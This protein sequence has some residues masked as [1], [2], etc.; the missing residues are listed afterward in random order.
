MKKTAIQTTLA[1]I[2]AACIATPVLGQNIEAGIDL[3]YLGLAQSEGQAVGFGFTAAPEI[4]VR[5]TTPSG[6]TFGLDAFRLQGTS[7]DP[8]TDYVAIMM[9]SID[10]T[11]GKNIDLGS[12]TQAMLYGGLRYATY[13]EDRAFNF[14]EVPQAWG[15]LAGV[16]VEHAMGSN[17]S[18]YG[19]SEAGIV[20][21]PNYTD[22]GSAEQN[23]IFNTIDLDLG[24][25]YSAS[26]GNGG[27]WFV[28]GGLTAKLWNGVSDN[29]SENISAYG[30][31]LSV[32]MNF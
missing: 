3:N 12:N 28:K 4:W 7:T 19:G 30:L 27:S 15:M 8:A 25:K 5:A 22:D 26:M 14:L 21:A 32:G 20:F 29:D 24:M 2:F 17:F 16:E 11:V 1:G 6:L 13:R 31:K 18:L 10:L 9:Q 23:L